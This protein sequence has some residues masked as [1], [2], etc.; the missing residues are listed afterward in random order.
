MRQKYK[1]SFIPPKEMAKSLTLMHVFNKKSLSLK[2]VLALM[3]P[4]GELKIKRE[5]PLRGKE[6]LKEK[7]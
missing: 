3:P 2:N 7:N 5:R 6:K 4:A 1:T